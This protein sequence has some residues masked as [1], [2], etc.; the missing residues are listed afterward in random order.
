MFAVVVLRAELTRRFCRTYRPARSILVWPASEREFIFRTPRHAALDAWGTVGSA[1]ACDA[2]EACRQRILYSKVFSNA[3]N[4]PSG[5][6]RECASLQILAAPSDLRPHRSIV[7]SWRCP[8][9]HSSSRAFGPGNVAQRCTGDAGSLSYADRFRPRSISSSSGDASG[10]G[11]LMG[12]STRVSGPRLGESVDFADMGDVDCRSGTTA[13]EGGESEGSLPA[14]ANPAYGASRFMRGILVK[15]ARWGSVEVI[16][17]VLGAIEGY[18]QTHTRRER[19]GNLRAKS[20]PLVVGTQD[21]AADATADQLTRESQDTPAMSPHTRNL[22][23]P[24]ALEEGATMLC[25]AEVFYAHGRLEI[26][27]FR[28]SPRRNTTKH[29]FSRMVIRISPLTTPHRNLNVKHIARDYKSNDT[30]SIA[31]SAFSDLFI[32]SSKLEVGMTRR[33]CN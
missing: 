5:Q 12:V 31:T 9:R 2:A 18:R 21:T 4:A 7:K 27:V 25:H 14:C 16:D 29:R 1:I 8:R 15:A 20:C 19:A 6:A 30:R 11:Q 17:R 24:R 23:L 28:V 13:C 3:A 33:I 22:Q 26:G 10:R 32:Y